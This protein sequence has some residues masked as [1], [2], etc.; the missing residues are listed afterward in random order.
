M[1]LKPITHDE[2]RQRLNEGTVQFAFKKLNG[3]LRTAV[4]TTCLENIPLQNHPT[5]SRAS[6]ASVVRY[7][8]ISTNWWR[9]VSIDREVFIAE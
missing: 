9:S 6:S 1:T 5:G 4:G 2:L 3:D 8:D 7:F